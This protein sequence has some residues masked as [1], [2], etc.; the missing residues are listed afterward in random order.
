MKKLHLAVL[1]STRGTGLQAILDAIQA[2]RL[3]AAVETVISD[4]SDSLI[5]SRSRQYGIPCFA[6]DPKN[7]TRAV[8]DQEM[9]SILAR[10][11]IDLILL[12]GYMRILSP[13][14]VRQYKDRI[15]NVHPSLLP[16]FSGGIDINVHGAVLNSGV[17]ESGCTIHIVDEGIDTGKIIIQKKCSVLPKDT[18]ET[19]KTR[20][21]ALEAEAW[22]E[23]LAQYS[24][25]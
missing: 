24:N 22:R 3:Y 16:R 21:Q 7:K 20:V 14:F 5:L 18:P 23:V 2:G 11:P 19:L 4:R 1:G 9:L 12:I 25:E 13:G 17:K 10:Y 8:F 6:L 15:L